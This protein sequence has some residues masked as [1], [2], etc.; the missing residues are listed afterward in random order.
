MLGNGVY[1]VVEQVGPYLVEPRAI[2]M[3]KREVGGKI[4]FDDYLL[5]A[6]LMGEDDE[7]GVNTVVDVN[8]LALSLAF[9]GIRFDCVNEIGDAAD[10]L[11]DGAD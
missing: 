1:G 11:F 5:F 2:R 4:L 6:Q 9:V 10:T 3:Q 7:G 8:G